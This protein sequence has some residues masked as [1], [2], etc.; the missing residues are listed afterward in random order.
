MFRADLPKPHGGG[1]RLR[2]SAN[3]TEPAAWDGRIDR[4]RPY[5]EYLSASD[6]PE[7]RRTPP[8]RFRRDFLCRNHSTSAYPRVVPIGGESVIRTRSCRPSISRYTRANFRPMLHVG[9]RTSTVRS[10]VSLTDPMRLYRDG[11]RP[12]IEDVDD[13]L[14]DLIRACDSCQTNPLA[15]G[16]FF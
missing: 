14:P 10:D 12:F 13:R 8:L 16:T 11:I 1:R 7:T 3:R 15:K 6:G 2:S 5:A 4:I 9:N